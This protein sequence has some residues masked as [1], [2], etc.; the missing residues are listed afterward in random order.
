VSIVIVCPPSVRTEL[1]KHALQAEQVDS[2][3]ASAPAPAEH[4]DS[5]ISVEECVAA[6]ID[7]ADR[8]LRKAYFPAKA[9]MGVYVRPFLPDLVDHFVRKSAKL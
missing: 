2:A 5:A 4:N 8:R 3:A 9:Y 6:I 7:A 1:R